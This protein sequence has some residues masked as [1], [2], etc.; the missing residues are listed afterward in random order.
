MKIEDF[1]KLKTE[2]SVMTRKFTAWGPAEIADTLIEGDGP[3]DPRIHGKLNLIKV[4]EAESFDDAL[5]QYHE[6][7]GWEPHRPMD[8]A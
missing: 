7:Q 5:R 8:E 4:F 2:L 6:F 3:P 1:G